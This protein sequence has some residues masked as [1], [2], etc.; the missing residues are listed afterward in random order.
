VLWGKFGAAVPPHSLAVVEIEGIDSEENLLALFRVVAERHEIL[1]TR[2]VARGDGPPLQVVEPPMVRSVAVDWRDLSAAELSHSMNRKLDEMRGL[3]SDANSAELVVRLARVKDRSWL[4]FLALGAIRADRYTMSR[5]VAELRAANEGVALEAPLQYADLAEWLINRESANQDNP[6]WRGQWREASLAPPRPAAAEQAKLRV[7]RRE[8]RPDTSVDAVVAAW[9][10]LLWR[11]FQERQGPVV[12]ALETDATRGALDGAHRDRAIGQFTNLVPLVIPTDPMSRFTDHLAETARRRRQAE[13]MSPS[14]LPSEEGF[15]FSW[16]LHIAEMPRA[17]S[18]GFSLLHQEMMLEPLEL[19]LGIVRGERG[20]TAELTY[21]C[22]TSEL[23]LDALEE[24]LARYLDRPSL[25]LCDGDSLSSGERTGIVRSSM[26][27]DAPLPAPIL[28]HSS[29]EAQMQRTPKA[30]AVEFAGA[31]L[32]YEELEASAA[33]LAV[34]LQT[35]GARPDEIV[36]VWGERCLEFPVAL[37]ATIQ[38]GSA[39]LALDPDLPPDRLADI[40]DDAAPRL[41]LVPSSKRRAIP[42]LPCQIVMFDLEVTPGPSQPRNPN[43]HPDNLA[44]V[45][46]TSGSTGKPKGALVSH[47]AIVNQMEWVQAE[48]PHD[49]GDH[50]LL[51]TSC[52]FDPSVWEVFWPLMTGGR[53]VIALPTGH[54]DPAYLNQ[55]MAERRV[56][57][58][59]FVPSMLMSVLADPGIAKVTSF[60]RILAGG[61]AVSMHV[62]RH[63]HDTVPGDFLHLYGPAEAAIAVLGAVIPRDLDLPF[64]PL[65]M[66]VCNSGVYLLDEFQQLVPDG[67]VGEICIGGLAL[68][69]GYLRLPRRTAQTFVP[70]PICGTSGS[71]MYRTGDLARRHPDG[72]I[73]F[74]GRADR[75]V[76]IH[77][78]RVELS[79]VEFH[80]NALPSVRQG[81][82]AVERDPAG[83]GKRLIAYVV[84]AD[85][86]ENPKLLRSQMLERLP[87]YMVPSDYIIV[88]A[89]PLNMNGKLDRKKLADMPREKPVQMTGSGSLS[90]AG[91]YLAAIWKDVLTVEQVGADT[92]FFL[93]GGHSLLAVKVT[94]RIERDL[95]ITM[96]LRLMLDLT[97]V[98]TLAPAL[99]F[100][101]AARLLG[102]AA[103]QSEK[104]LDEYAA[105]VASLRSGEPPSKLP[106]P[107]GMTTAQKDEI[108]SELQRALSPKQEASI[109][110]RGLR[111]ARLSFAQQSMWF[112]EQLSPGTGSFNVPAAIRLTGG[113]L[114]RKRLQLALDALIVRHESLR[115]VFT[116]VDGEPAQRVLTARPALLESAD[117]ADFD[118]LKAG[119]AVEAWRP[120]DLETGPLIRANL[121][122]GPH[123]SVLL[124]TLHHLIC[125]DWSIGVLTRDLLALYADARA[126][127]PP[128][129]VQYTDFAEWQREHCD[130]IEVKAQLGY[131]KEQL[132]GLPPELPLPADPV[133][134]PANGLKKTGGMRQV[135]LAPS[136]GQQLDALAKAHHVTPFMLLTAVLNVLLHSITGE[137]D[138]VIGSPFAV[139]GRTEL[140][141]MIGL[142]INPVVIRTRFSADATFAEVLD[143]TRRP[144][145]AA[146]SNA[147]V[148]FEQVLKVLDT[149]GSRSPFRVWFSLQSAPAPNVELDNIQTDRLFLEPEYAKFDLALLLWQDS[150]SGFWEFRRSRLSGNI[151]KIVSFWQHIVE[152]VASETCPPLPA[153]RRSWL[154]QSPAGGTTAAAAADFRAAAERS[155]SQRVRSRPSGQ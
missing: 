7:G 82:V 94:S 23:L 22:E 42:E 11:R 49:E 64:A 84:A 3:P 108:A 123:D 29:I 65:G 99:E 54:R 73:E 66:P 120:F 125:D 100:Q 47:R 87:S 4:A 141:N 53:I 69:R 75:Q 44:Y 152:L 153:L 2:I 13:E 21:R 103:S 146:Y 88:E 154:S 39:F 38:A 70:D 5:I 20:L 9:T 18:S 136:S 57:S 27:K 31:S 35:L 124:I 60:G 41:L 97:T 110:S 74:V 45:I 50:M 139:R 55:V 30:L 67:V 151:E 127:L 61:E 137:T 115:T 77:G 90:P 1:R 147:D 79:D 119:L 89:M 121:L 95:G 149:P 34:K 43:L 81:A 32:T 133:S 144:I 92:D 28:F 143:R 116:G 142:M 138:I 63:F 10:L 150:L 80:L 104:V 40:V 33:A 85:D 37:L 111:K 52:G 155:L 91:R 148:P 72:N 71:R 134:P 86:L 101:I 6:F 15:S 102:L 98:A 56:S 130:R 109:S 122:N 51:K 117:Y 140:E 118:A 132:R 128:M 59:Y 24:E 145:A 112:Q 135:N 14:F 131:W 76:K 58:T 114:D 8:L 48:W 78:S 93:S 126:K 62:I 83:A 68:G 26:G 113:Q 36:A 19:T 46:Y 129:A 16:G 105:R 96:P 25:L 17:L 107:N 12:M 106:L